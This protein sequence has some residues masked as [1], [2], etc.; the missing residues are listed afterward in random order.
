MAVTEERQVLERGEAVTTISSLQSLKL[1]ARYMVSSAH[2][3]ATAAGVRILERG[4]N[5]ADAGV[6]AGLVINVV[7]P[8][9]TNFGGVAPIIFAR[10]DGH[11]ETI[12]GL[13]RWPKAATL[14]AVRERG[15]GDLPP[16]IL[17]TITPAAVDAWIT[18]LAR[19]GSMSFAQIAEPAIDLAENGFPVYRRLSSSIERSAETL[20]RWPSSAQIFLPRGRPPTLGERLVQS[21]LARLL[22]R[23]AGAES[24]ADGDRAARLTA[25]RDEF[26]RG[27]PARRMAEFCQAQGGFLTERDLADFAVKVEPPERVT[28]K[29]YEVLSC[30]PWCQGPILLQ[31][32]AIIEQADVPALG[33]NSARYLH[34]LAETIKLVM[35][36]RERYY[37]DPEHVDVPMVGLLSW[38]YAAER[39]AQID[40]N[41]AAPGLPA[42]GDP[43]PY[44][45][46]RGTRGDLARPVVL[47]G[48]R[49]PD[50]SYSCAVDADGNAFSATPSDPG[51]SSPI[52]PGL[53]ILI[54]SR[55]S[56]SWLDPGHASAV[57]PWK[58]PR[59]T[60]NPAMVLKDGRPYMP[61]GCPGGDAQTQAMLQVFL[62][63]VEFGMDPQQAVE[64]PR[65]I[66][67]SF[68]NSFWPHA[69]RPG[70][71][72]VENRIPAETRAELAQLGH[73]VEEWP[74]FTPAA[75]GVCAIQVDPT[76]GVRV[77]GADPRRE[78]V[79]LGW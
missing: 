58:R 61:F 56:Q 25:A 72:A 53:G 45:G 17:R 55:G 73:L 62:N 46:R 6:A 77:G 44:L 20:R 21:D 30:G 15:G 76:T 34:L 65:V 9:L 12:S 52:V 63:H 68:P 64:A 47:D 69:Y 59:L 51:F 29:D 10:A 36:D 66:S 70:V 50:T 37:G 23:L 24:A 5:A 54:S 41:H 13:G 19:F 42:P 11:V 57:A 74:A 33:H 39:R 3:L 26:Y 7:E 75:A 35:A 48:P 71:L 4:G 79:A 67:W 14:D 8:H 27:E 78:S 60:P 1:G 32:L 40:P 2:Y 43:W 18:A 28:Y 38:E 31:F 16:G 22:R 49:P